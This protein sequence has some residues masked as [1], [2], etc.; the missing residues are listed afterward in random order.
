MGGFNYWSRAGTVSKPNF[1]TNWW[2]T[3]WKSNKLFGRKKVWALANYKRKRYAKRSLRYSRYLHNRYNYRFDCNLFLEVPEIQHTILFK[4]N[5]NKVVG[6]DLSLPNIC[7]IMNLFFYPVDSSTESKI[8]QFKYLFNYVKCNGIKVTYKP[9]SITAPEETFGDSKPNLLFFILK[10]YEYSKFKSPN[11]DTSVTTN[12]YYAGLN[13]LKDSQFA[14]ITS[15]DDTFEFYRPF[16]YNKSCDNTGADMDI[17]DRFI[18]RKWTIKFKC[19]I[20]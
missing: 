4:T 19:I 1:I 2:K 9:Y 14:R 18:I 12:S 11:G 8:G 7:D 10:D 16:P 13:S 3:W 15:Y 20:I 6:G 5:E 17:F